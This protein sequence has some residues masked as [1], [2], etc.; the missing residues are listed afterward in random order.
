MI[1]DIYLISV[2]LCLSGMLLGIQFQPM[3]EG[4]CFLP[5]VVIIV[6]LIPLINIIFFIFIIFVLLKETK[7]LEKIGRFLIKEI[8]F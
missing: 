7:P 8:K 6:S 2:A 3:D 1:L 4:D 5:Y